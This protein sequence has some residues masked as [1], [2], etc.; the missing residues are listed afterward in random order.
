MK[1]YDA[2]I[3]HCVA[4]IVAES[5]FSLRNLKQQCCGW[6]RIC[7][8]KFRIHNNAKKSSIKS[9]ISIEADLTS[10]LNLISNTKKLTAQNIWQSKT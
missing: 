9:Q 7:N 4:S 8:E 2:L 6:I 10:S 1:M 3:I 5:L